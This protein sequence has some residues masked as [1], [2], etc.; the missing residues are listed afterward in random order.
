V[1][2]RDRVIAVIGKAGPYRGFTRM[3]ADWAIARNAKI[4]KDRRKCKAKPLKHRGTEEA[5]E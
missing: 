5:E 1:I 2:A 4:A 3:S